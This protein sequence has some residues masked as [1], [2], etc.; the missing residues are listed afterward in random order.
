M[1][2]KIFVAES[3][4]QLTINLPMEYLHKGI[5]VIAFEVE[6]DFNSVA[7]AKKTAARNAIQFFK[8][9]QIDMSDFKFDR[10]EANKR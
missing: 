8:T 4:S 1:F 6:E 2:R 3:A 9:L 5:E 10:D 7:L